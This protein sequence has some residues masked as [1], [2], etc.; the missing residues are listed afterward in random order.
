MTNTEAILHL[1]ENLGKPTDLIPLTDFNDLT[2]F[3]STLY[4]YTRLEQW[5][6]NGCERVI[7]WKSGTGRRPL[8]ERPVNRHTF[9]VCPILLSSNDFDAFSDQSDSGY[10]GFELSEAASQIF[11]ST[12]STFI[13]TNS[14]LK[15]T[16]GYNEG[17]ESPVYFQKI[18]TGS[19]GGGLQSY[20]YSI[21]ILNVDDI[22][23]ADL[24]QALI[25]T[26]VQIC[27]RAFDLQGVFEEPNDD[28]DSYKYLY[29]YRD[30]AIKR[31]IDIKSRVTL[32]RAER[33]SDFIVDK[34]ESGVPY[35]YSLF[36]GRYIVFDR[37]IDENRFYEF[38]Y[39]ENS[40]LT[41]SSGLI[42]IPTRFHPLIVIWAS[43][44]GKLRYQENDEAYSYRGMFEQDMRGISSDEEFR[45]DTYE[46]GFN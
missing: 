39:V 8:L 41:L 25:D 31:I 27:P 9:T 34:D 38:E 19:P 29:H 40:P 21:N 37:Y 7:S 23:I 10:Y 12:Y 45:T 42:S 32:E 3:D 14:L 44:L 16:D 5:L 13:A 11:D 18:V 33:Q 20:Y 1:W 6:K 15:I 43:Y 24:T 46:G 35:E 2:S 30:I 22:T 17:Y 26:Y 36:S 28:Q 4:G